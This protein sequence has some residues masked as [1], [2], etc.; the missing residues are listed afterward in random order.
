M[1]A[2]QHRMRCRNPEMFSEKRILEITGKDGGPVATVEVPLDEIKK[3]LWAAYGL[4][5]E[6]DDEEEEEP[7]GEA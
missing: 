4:D 3:R 1:R 7:G 6:D 5:I 2:L